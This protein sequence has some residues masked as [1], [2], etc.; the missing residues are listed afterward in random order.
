MTA[1][2]H[3]G[4]TVSELEASIAFYQALLG[5]RILERSSGSGPELETLTGIPGVRV[6]TADLEVPGG[7][8]LELVQYL[9]PPSARLAQER[10]QAGH[11]HVAFVVESIDAAL[12]RLTVLGITSA[13]SPVTI[14]EPGSA[15][16]GTRVLYACDPDG[17]TI[18][19]LERPPRY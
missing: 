6:I 15:W 4:F 3:V 2:H 8:I 1:L 14:A 19:C 5:C 7:G 18:E 10:H 17:R 9:A 11:T 16:D 12:E 13:S